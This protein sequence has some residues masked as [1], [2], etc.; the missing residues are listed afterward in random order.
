MRFAAA[1]AVA[2]GCLSASAMPLGLRTAMWGAESGETD[3]GSDV[4]PIVEVREV[5][6]NANGGTVSESSRSVSSGSVVGALPTPVWKDHAFDGWFTKA[7]GGTK[8]AATTLVTADVTFYAHW[9]AAGGGGQGGGESG[10]QDPIVPVIKLAWT[11]TKA[12]TLNGAVYDKDGNAVGVVQ[13]KVAKPK[14][15]KRT[16]AVTA[17][18]S[19]YVMFADGKKKTLKSVTADV[20]RSAPI[21]FSSAVKNLGTLTAKIG[22]DGFCGT[23]GDWSVRMAQVGGNWTKTD[24]VVCVDFDGGSVLPSGTIEGLLPDGERVIA[25][26]GKWSFNKAASVKLK[27]GAIVGIDDPKKPNLSAMKL[28]YTPKTGI[29]KGSF[30]IYAVQGGKL[31]KLSV[32]V[33]GFVVDGVGCGQA[34]LAKPPSSWLLS[35]E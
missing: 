27:N 13:L 15:N 34:T 11:A 31:K 6:F 22:D 29:F 25:K 2:I 30:K 24:A 1:M 10:G 26:S 16:G 8:I 5:K 3:A 23:I 20:P 4:A 7:N 17:K 32:K 28:T 21:S 9:T 14:A 35:V 12:A 33:S 19:G 18:V